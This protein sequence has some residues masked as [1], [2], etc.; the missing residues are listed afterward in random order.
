MT[1]Q[2]TQNQKFFNLHIQALGYVNRIR[3]VTPKKGQPYLALDFAALSGDSNSPNYTYFNAS[4]V[5]AEAQR[6]VRKLKANLDREPE[7]KILASVKL[8]DLSPETF[9]YEKGK[10]AG[11]TGVRLYTRLLKFSMVRI[12]GRTVFSESEVVSEQPGEVA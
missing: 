11:Q 8:G 5:G 1:N 9:V 10:R 2:N 7:A 12:D 3:E 4:V 6:I